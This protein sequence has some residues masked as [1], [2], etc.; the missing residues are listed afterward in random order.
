MERS[1]RRVATLAALAA[2][3]LLP[4]ASVQAQEEAAA[5][6]ERQQFEK[7]VG[8]RATGNE[9]AEESQKR[10]DSLSDETDELLAKYRTTWKQIE[11]IDAYNRQMRDLLDA[12][13]AELA[14][15]GNQLERV[16]SVSRS[17]TPLMVRMI[18]AV[19]QFVELDVPFLKKERKERVDGL[20][21]LMRRADVTTAEKFRQIMEAY[22][23][24]NEYGRTIEAYRS[25][26]DI[27]GKETTVDFLRF[28]RVALVYQS[29]DEQQAGA[30]SQKE[31]KWVPLDS[32]HR[33]ALRAGL[34]IARKQAAP[35]LIRLPLPAAVDAREQG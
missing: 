12:Q 14:S 3:T 2:I 9:A 7:V 24:E 15:L 20:R 27:D 13:Q 6:A 31:R 5:S 22:Q 26:I 25:T 29:L 16:Q 4:G 32:S 1:R 17:V 21:A 19:D 30:W 18:D 33:S 28:G 23:V 8:A 35:D 10:V 34:R 11:S